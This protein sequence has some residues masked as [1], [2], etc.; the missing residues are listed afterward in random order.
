MICGS[1]EAVITPLSI[2]GFCR[3]KSI[4]IHSNENPKLSSCPFDK[5]RSGFVMGEGS[6]ILVLE[7][8]EH[9][10]NRNANIYCEIKGIGVSSDA[11]HI[12]APRPD[13]KGIMLSMN[14]ALKM[15]NV[16]MNEIDYVNAHATSTLLG[17]EIELRGI[18]KLVE[19]N[20]T[21]HKV[22]VSSLKG[23]IGHLLGAAGSVETIITI[24]SMKNN[25]L[26]PT[27]NLK[28]TNISHSY[29]ELIKDK[30]INYDCKYCL[31]NSF[32]FGGTN[33]SIVIKKC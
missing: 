28:E 13:S 2:A 9:A 21:N 11:Y 30:F 15:A 20:K 29:T 10:M 16:T 31:K 27:Y 32:G 8:Y 19:M 24:L 17:D 18:D 3:S 33:T 23:N 6:G 14:K 25:M 5:K 4:T 1:T 7:D 22:F 12:T 26:L